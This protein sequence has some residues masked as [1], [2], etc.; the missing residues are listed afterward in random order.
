[1]LYLIVTVL[2]YFYLKKF[3]LDEHKILLF[4]NR[5]QTF[6]VYV[7]QIVTVKPTIIKFWITSLKHTHTH[8]LCNNKL[9]EFKTW[10]L[11]NKCVSWQWNYI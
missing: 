4:K 6:E 1:M 7:G 5:P 8:T 3:S 2:L 11:L 9:N 10:Q